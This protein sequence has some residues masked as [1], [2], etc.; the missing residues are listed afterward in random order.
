MHPIIGQALVTER[1]R[2]AERLAGR[3][4]IPHLVALRHRDRAARRAARTRRRTS[5]SAWTVAS[6]SEPQEWA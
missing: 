2:E 6:G 5:V 3:S 4:W 1:R